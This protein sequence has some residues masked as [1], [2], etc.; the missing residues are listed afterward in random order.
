[1][2]WQPEHSFTHQSDNNDG[3][4]HTLCVKFQKNIQLKIF[5]IYYNPFALRVPVSLQLS[6]NQCKRQKKGGKEKHSG[7]GVEWE[8]DKDW[9]AGEK[10]LCAGIC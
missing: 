8:W 6:A 1:M 4:L 5:I 10:Y 7:T 2:G 9:M 3:N